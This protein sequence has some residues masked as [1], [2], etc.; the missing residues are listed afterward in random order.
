L[1]AAAAADSSPTHAVQFVYQR[2]GGLV[3]LCSLPSTRIA[4]DRAAVAK[5]RGGGY[6]TLIRYATATPRVDT[7]RADTAPSVKQAPAAPTWSSVQTGPLPMT[8]SPR[9]PGGRSRS[10]RGPADDRVPQDRGDRARAVVEGRA[11]A[12]ASAFAAFSGHN[13]YRRHRLRAPATAITT[14]RLRRG[15][16]LS[17]PELA[18]VAHLPVDEHVPG[19]LRA[20]AAAV[21]PPPPIPL[22]GPGVKPLGDSDATPGRPVGVTV[23]MA[24]I[25][26]RSSARPAARSRP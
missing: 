15:D 7:A 4:H 17:V 1:N 8:I 12:V 14:R 18:A 6:E 5:A 11:H 19:L 10:P 25:T 22:P 23:P 9:V 24:A 26:C 2:A 21:A 20:G 13:H 3:A 16:V